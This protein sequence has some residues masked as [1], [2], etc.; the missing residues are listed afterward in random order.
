MILPKKVKSFAKKSISLKK[1]RLNVV[2]FG[3]N[4]KKKKTLR[5]KAN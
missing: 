1:L 5:V 4:G 3:K 2:A